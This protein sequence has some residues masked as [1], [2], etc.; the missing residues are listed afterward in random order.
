MQ[1]FEGIVEP[2]MHLHSSGTRNSVDAEIRHEV[3]ESGR[4]AEANHEVLP[5]DRELRAV[6]GMRVFACPVGLVKHS[7]QVVEERG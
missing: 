5:N 6:V 1:Y 4:A 2:S 3:L 7:L